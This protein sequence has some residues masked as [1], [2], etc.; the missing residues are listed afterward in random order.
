MS[1]GG[2][3]KL[4]PWQSFSVPNSKSRSQPHGGLNYVVYP[5]CYYK[6]AALRYAPV[7]TENGVLNT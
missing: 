4:E 1:A 3:F 2:C 6:A 5:A 7:A